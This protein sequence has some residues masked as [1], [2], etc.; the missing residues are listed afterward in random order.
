MRTLAGLGTALVLLAAVVALAYE[1]PLSCVVTSAGT[2]AVSTSCSIPVGVP[3]AVQCDAA[4]CVR[5]VLGAGTV[6]C[7]AGQSNTGVKLSAGQLYDLP[8]R[9][10]GSD[11]LNVD[12]V[13][14]ISVSGTAN[15]EVFR[16][17][18]P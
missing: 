11:D 15:C 1:K 12:E 7:T 4:A 17:V 13:A 6:T 8:M 3:L 5:A 10:S 9:Y 2:T 14:V 18:L 16:V